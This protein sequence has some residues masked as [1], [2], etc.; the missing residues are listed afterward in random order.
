[1]CIRDSNWYDTHDLRAL[2]PKY[3]S[4]VDSGN[5]AGHL[6]VLGNACR[7]MVDAPFSGVQWLDGIDDALEITRESVRG[8]S[9]DRRTLNVTQ[10]HLGNAIDA[11]SIAVSDSLSSAEAT[12]AGL[13]NLSARLALRAD[14]L[15]DIC[16]LYTSR[17]V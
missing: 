6:I 10:K 15:I 4:S 8:L 11:L 12:P 1:M 5:L 7:Q 9:D 3:V 14:T 16:L 2:D 13:I 17:C